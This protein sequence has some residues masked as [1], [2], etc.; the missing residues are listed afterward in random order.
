MSINQDWTAEMNV[1]QELQEKHLLTDRG[2]VFH[3]G[4]ELD[5]YECMRV[6]T[7]EEINEKGMSPCSKCFPSLQLEHECLLNE[8]C[9]A[10]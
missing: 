7:V 3:N 2:Y 6:V 4:S 1:G 8:R 5:S 9:Q 10:I